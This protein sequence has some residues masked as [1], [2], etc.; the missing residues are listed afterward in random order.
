MLKSRKSLHLI[1]KDLN[2]FKLDTTFFP[3]KLLSIFFSE[4]KNWDLN[5]KFSKLSYIKYCS[6]VSMQLRMSRNGENYIEKKLNI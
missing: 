3:R 6:Y 5:L 1:F 4:T 2:N